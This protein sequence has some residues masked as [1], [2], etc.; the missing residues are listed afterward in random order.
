MTRIPSLLA[1]CAVVALPMGCGNKDKGTQNPDEAAEGDVDPLEE[2]KSIPDQIQ[3]EVDTV[4]QPINDVDVV[5]DQVTT[6]PD[7]LGVDAAGLRALAKAS[8]QSG[9]VSVEL[10]V[11]AEAKAEIEGVLKTIN[12]IAVGLKETPQRATAATKN[13]VAMGAKA[14][15]LVGKLQAKYQAKLSNPLAKAEDKAKIQ[16]DLNAV[17]QLDGEIKA[18]VADAKSTV[19]GLPAKGT[20][21]LAKLTAAFAGSAGDGGAEA[22]AG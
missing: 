7:R 14:T 18:I 16:A 12:G 4:L 5:V 20:E 10:D 6:M 2:L 22:S 8:L 9:E 21:A 15:A 17:M 1:L 11:T 13:I 19:T 3:A